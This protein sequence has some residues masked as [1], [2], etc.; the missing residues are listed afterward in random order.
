MFFLS[1]CFGTAAG[2]RIRAGQQGFSV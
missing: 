1:V 2:W